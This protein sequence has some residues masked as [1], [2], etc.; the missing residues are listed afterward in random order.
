MIIEIKKFIIQCKDC[1]ETG[2]VLL[3]SIITDRQ[4]KT[5]RN[6]IVNVSFFSLGYWVADFAQ[7]DKFASLIVAF[8][9]GRYTA[10][11]DNHL[12]DAI[13]NLPNIIKMYW[14]KK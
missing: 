12:N 8:T 10:Q 11:L 5:I 2:F 9:T 3:G 6:M 7:L 13:G 14:R 4:Q 1:I